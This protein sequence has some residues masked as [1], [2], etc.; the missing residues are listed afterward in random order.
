MAEAT[1]TQ[2]ARFDRRLLMLGFGCVGRGVLP[3]LLRHIAIAPGQIR[4]L[5]A[6]ETGAGVAAE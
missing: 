6:G 2:F 1:H 5:N 4:I 3:L